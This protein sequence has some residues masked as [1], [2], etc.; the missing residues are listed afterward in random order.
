MFR[1]TAKTKLE[2]R[3]PLS[4]LEFSVSVNLRGNT[5]ASFL[6]VLFGFCLYEI[7]MHLK[8]YTHIILKRNYINGI[9]LYIYF[10]YLLFYAMYLLFLHI[11]MQG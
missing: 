7:L 3:R 8:I 10:Y 11:H 2:N 4:C 1:V 6:C 5:F 9:K